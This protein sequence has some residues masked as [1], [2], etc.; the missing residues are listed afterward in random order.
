MPD[1]EHFVFPSEVGG[2]K[3]EKLGQPP[4]SPEFV[5]RGI[6]IIPS[7]PFEVHHPHPTVTKN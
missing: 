7:Y 6:F 2:D 1:D 3:R 5:F 4:G